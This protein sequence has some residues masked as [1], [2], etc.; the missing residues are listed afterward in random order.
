MKLSFGKLQIR[1]RKKPPVGA[2]TFPPC[3]YWYFTF[4]YAGNIFQSLK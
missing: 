1:E 4:F 3:P 2:G